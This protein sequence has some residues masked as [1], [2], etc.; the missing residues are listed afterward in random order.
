TP[1]TRFPYTT[2]FRSIWLILQTQGF[3]KISWRHERRNNTGDRVLTIST[4]RI[5]IATVKLRLESERG[6][7]RPAFRQFV[8][9]LIIPEHT[10]VVRLCQLT[11][12]SD[13]TILQVNLCSKVEIILCIV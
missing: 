1:Y 3:C 7:D 5:G 12:V 9:K 6:I 13:L 11:F 4:L 2:L 10:V 8:G